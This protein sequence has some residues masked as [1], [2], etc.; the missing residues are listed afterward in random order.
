MFEGSHK[1]G[2]VGVRHGMLGLLIVLVYN[3]AETMSTEAFVSPFSSSASRACRPEMKPLNPFQKNTFSQ[4]ILR[5]ATTSS[6][7]SSSSQLSSTSF[8]SLKDFNEHL[9]KMVQKCSFL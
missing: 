1:K 6:L 5:S 8:G 3:S 4:V 9:E 2:R 7:Q